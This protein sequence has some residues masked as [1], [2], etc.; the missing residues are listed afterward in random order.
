MQKIPT[1]LPE[2]SDFKKEL[3]DYHASEDMKI[4]PKIEDES[5]N[6]R[7]QRKLID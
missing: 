1:E 4:T 2:L 5:I 3:L 6:D 7:V